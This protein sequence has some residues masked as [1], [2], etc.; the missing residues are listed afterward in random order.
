MADGLSRAVIDALLPDGSFWDVKPDGFFDLLLDALGEND[1]RIADDLCCIANIRDPFLTPILDDL[2]K[3][4]GIQTDTNLTEAQRRGQLAALVYK[5]DNNGS[6][7]DLQNALVA[8]GFDVQ[9]HENS[10]AVDPD[11]FLNNIFL[12][13]ANGDNAYA[14]FFPTTPG[15]YTSVAGK[16][17]GSLLVNGKIYEQRPDYTTVAGFVYAGNEEGI[18]GS[19][20]EL[21]QNE[22]IYPIPDDPNSWPFFF[23]VGGDA[24]R[25]INGELTAIEVVDI[26]I[27]RRAIF[28]RIILRYKPIHTWAG[29]MIN[30]T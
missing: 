9:V 8:A 17:G 1:D 13:V 21:V 6:K 11:T 18:A 20:T 30:Y 23:F 29:L 3:E 2:E 16:T 25:D 22:I 14:G 12:M 15:E 10:P 24:T 27:Q 5:G 4:Y 19:Y 28:E 7:D 26:P